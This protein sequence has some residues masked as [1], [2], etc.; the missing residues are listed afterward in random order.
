MKLQIFESY[1]L[2]A[3]AGCESRERMV[4]LLVAVASQ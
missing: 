2:D 1:P 4:L 3:N